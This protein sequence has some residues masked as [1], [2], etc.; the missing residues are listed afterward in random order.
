MNLHIVDGYKINKLKDMETY[1]L[2]HKDELGSSRSLKS[3]LIE[4]R[5]HNVLYNLGLFRSHTKD[6]DL[7]DNESILRRFC[8]YVIWVI[9]LSFLEYRNLRRA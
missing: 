9:T 5:A 2:Q 7:D 4:W 8:Y 3:Y 6:T 1:L